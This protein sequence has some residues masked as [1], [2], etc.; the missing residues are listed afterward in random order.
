MFYLIAF[1]SESRY[2]A[3]SSARHDLNLGLSYL[4]YIWPYVYYQYISVYIATWTHAHT[5]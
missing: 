1:Y 4:H 5:F 2:S 3:A